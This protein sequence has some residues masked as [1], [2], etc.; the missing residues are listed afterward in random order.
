MKKLEQQLARILQT[1]SS[2]SKHVGQIAK[3][4]TRST[5]AAKGASG[6]ASGKKT[7]GA[8]ARVR[9]DTV[10]DS[11]F[12]TIKRNRSGI[13]IA[14]LKKKTDLGDRQLSNALYKL[15]KK[16]MVHA[17]SRGIYVKS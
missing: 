7:R 16:G 6:S 2:L 12:E 13:S 17:K 8:A 3:E 1:L 14:Q 4:V 10:L 5:A 9:R 15:T 11:V